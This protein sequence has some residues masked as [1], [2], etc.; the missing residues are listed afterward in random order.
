[1]SN[2]QSSRKNSETVIIDAGDTD[3]RSED[4]DIAKFLND[5]TVAQH[6]ITNSLLTNVLKINE[7]IKLGDEEG[8]DDDVI[9][10]IRVNP[11]IFTEYKPKSLK[12]MSG[13]RDFNRRCAKNVPEKKIKLCEE[14]ADEMRSFD[15]EIEGGLGKRS[16]YERVR[17]RE[18]RVKRKL[19]PICNDNGAHGSMNQ[20]LTAD[21]VIELHSSEDESANSS[22]KSTF[23][24]ENANDSI[25]TTMK[26]F[27]AYFEYLRKCVTKINFDQEMQRRT[28]LNE[29]F[30]VAVKSIET[31]ID[32]Y[33]QMFLRYTRKHHWSEKVMACIQSNTLREVKERSQKFDDG[34][35]ENCATQKRFAKYMLIFS[36][37]RLDACRLYEFGWTHRFGLHVML[38]IYLSLIE[39]TRIGSCKLLHVKIISTKKFSSMIL[40]T[41][42]VKPSGISVCYRRGRASHLLLY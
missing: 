19:E 10:V 42:Y 38:R 27:K 20:T 1:M 34:Y 37:Y 17:D 5:Y 16:E 36:G 12:E 41:R 8:K 13:R 21:R 35:C 22:P 6:S 3:D 23:R 2:D 30:H 32:R 24:S 9:E 15:V 26:D 28:S 40:A 33:R 31:E 14:V 7:A 18:K 29:R 39:S 11:S 25:K 4:E